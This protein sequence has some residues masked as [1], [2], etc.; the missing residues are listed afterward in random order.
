MPDAISPA[1]SGR[2]KCRG[3]SRAIAAGEL[4]FAESA[5]NPY[6]EGE[7]L[8]FYHLLCAACFRPERFG[9]TLEAYAEPPDGVDRLRAL[10][11]Q[12]LAHPRLVRLLRAERAPSGRAHCRSCRELIDKGAWRIALHI[13]EEGRFAPIGSIHVACAPTYFETADVIERLHQLT[14]DLDPAALAELTALLAAGPAGAPGDE[15]AGAA[16]EA[17]PPPAP[18]EAPSALEPPGIAKARARTAAP[19]PARAEPR[20]EAARKRRTGE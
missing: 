18:A 20:G 19:G 6:A 2:A 14:P 1:K 9:A 10:L 12:G 7:T 5:P 15:A 8:Y 4:R 17:H 16:P 11:E 13:Y 3:C